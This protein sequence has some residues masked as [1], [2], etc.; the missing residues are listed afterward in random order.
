VSLGE[1][2]RR[3]ALAI[4]RRAVA[5]EEVCVHPTHPLRAGG[6]EG[7]DGAHVLKARRRG[8]GK[9][10]TPWLVIAGVRAAPGL[11]LIGTPRAAIVAFAPGGYSPYALA[12][13]TE[14]RGWHIPLLQHPPAAH[15]CITVRQ[16]ELRAA[17]PSAGGSGGAGGADAQER[18]PPPPAAAAPAAAP[19]AAAPAAFPAATVLDAWLAD[20]AARAAPAPPPPATLSTPPAPLGGH[21]RRFPATRRSRPC[22]PRA[23]L[24]CPQQRAAGVR[25]VPGGRAWEEPKAPRGPRTPPRGVAMTRGARGCAVRA[26]GKRSQ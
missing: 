3:L 6:V 21:L 15:I 1:G 26:E 24:R 19:A 10:C 17:A 22:H 16:G 25:E 13:R 7:V 8:K 4:L 2:G 18:P 12:A 23:A 5:V 20:L 9:P 14:E 11:R